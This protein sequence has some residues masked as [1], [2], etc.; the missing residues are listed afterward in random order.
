ML[1][2]HRLELKKERHKIFL[3]NARFLIQEINNLENRIR[4]L[5]EE[6]GKNDPELVSAMQKKQDLETEYYKLMGDINKEDPELESLVYV[7]PATFSQVQSILAQDAI[8]I[9]YFQSFENLYIWTITS[10]RPIRCVDMDLFIVRR[11]CHF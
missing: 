8:V 1:G 9:N 2:S 6:K 3:G 7:E 5:S 11:N 4:I 10:D